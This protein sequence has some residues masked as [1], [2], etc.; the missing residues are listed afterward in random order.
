MT[1]DYMGPWIDQRIDRRLAELGINPDPIETGREAALGQWEARWAA[2]RLLC[3]NQFGGA[4]LLRRMDRLENDIPV[5]LPTRPIDP[6]ETY[7][8]PDPPV[9]Y[10]GRPTRLTADGPVE[11]SGS[12]TDGPEAPAG[13]EVPDYQEM[14]NRYYA[15]LVELRS[16]L[17]DH[18]I[19]RRDLGEDLADRLRV[20]IDE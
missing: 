5:G 16:R 9:V 17:I 19:T 7:G 8:P 12:Q 6:L 11:V 18:R 4:I 13:L 14:A 10:E 2:L 15:L 20:F 3:G 1:D